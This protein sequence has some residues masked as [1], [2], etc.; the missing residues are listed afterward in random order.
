[1]N[2]IRELGLNSVN[3]YSRS[4]KDRRINSAIDDNSNTSF[5]NFNEDLAVMRNYLMTFSEVKR[6][7]ILSL[8]AC[9]VSPDNLLYLPPQTIVK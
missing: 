1:M 9:H 2:Q 8:V 4:G 3:T 7:R 6:K 5:N